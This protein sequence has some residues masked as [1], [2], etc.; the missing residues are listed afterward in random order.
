MP[1]YS[2]TDRP[3]RLTTV[4]GPDAILITGFRGREALSELYRFELDVLVPRLRQFPFTDL[5]NSEA[6]VALVQANGR[7]RYFHG[8]IAAATEGNNDEEFISGQ[9]ELVPHFWRHTHCIR[10]RIFQRL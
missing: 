10:S 4:L 8:I 3:L 6:S 2:Q 5:L 9:L 7:T 1:T